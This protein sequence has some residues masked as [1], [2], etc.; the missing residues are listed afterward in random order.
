MDCF[1]INYDCVVLCVLYMYFVVGLWVCDL[2]VFV[3][4]CGNVFIKC[5]C[6]FE[7]YKRLLMI[8]LGKEIG[9]IVVCFGFVDIFG[10]F[11][12]GGF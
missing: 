3:G 11:D 10:D 4:G 2:F 9:M 12:V 7:C 6:Q 5:Y 8:N 1:G